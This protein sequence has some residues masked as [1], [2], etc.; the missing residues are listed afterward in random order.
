MSSLERFG[1]DREMRIGNAER[2]ALADLLR[3]SVDQGY[4][5]LDEYEKRVDVV[6]AA[7][8][9][10][11]AL[12]VLVDLPVYRTIVETEP[13]VK[14]GVPDWI[15]WMWFGFS[16]PITICLSIWLVIFFFT[17]HTYPWPIW[18]AAPFIGVGI[19]MTLAERFIMRPAEER[20]RREQLRRKR[21]EG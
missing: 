12:P 13:P 4:L 18:V 1:G 7:K 20:K 19:P 15:K 6:M 17:G 21:M 3:T 9:V 16:I 5:E 8:T 11:D 14:R 10:G 2:D